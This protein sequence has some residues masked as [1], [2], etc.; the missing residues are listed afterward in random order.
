[1][2]KIEYSLSF[3][4]YL[5]MAKSPKTKPDLRLASFA[6][7][8]GFA[9][10]VSG[11][12]ILHRSAEGPFVP[13]GLLLFGGLLFTFLAMIL[14]V[15]AKKKPASPDGSTSRREYELF[16]ADKRTF[17]YDETGWRLSWYEGE[18]ARSWDRI[19]QINNGQKL[20]VL[21]TVTTFYWLP[22]DAL[23]R[24]GHYDKIVGLAEGAISSHGK[25]FDVPMRPSALVYVV[26]VATNNWRRRTMTQLLTYTAAILG[27]YWALASSAVATSP[28]RYWALLFAPVGIFFLECMWYLSAYYKV[29]W[30]KGASDAEI[31]S[32]CI[33]Y[34]S[35]K[36]RWIA[37]YSRLEEVCEV[38][39]AFLLYFSKDS[40]HL[41]PKRGFSPTQLAQFRN[42]IGAAR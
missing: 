2:P 25:L 33:A 24:D 6:S 27:A 8:V 40:Y 12:F 20:L 15:F 36:A 11:Y 30:S 3:E 18:D 38:P 19:R 26:A 35:P 21:G 23:E 13:G 1:M 7:F 32:D 14:G 31:M 17:E 34:R 37:E 28:Q 41:I 10:I 4:N 42:L 16:H 29:D 9:G 5:E 22:N 39:G